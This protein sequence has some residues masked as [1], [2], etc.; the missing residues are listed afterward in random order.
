MPPR[1]YVANQRKTVTRRLMVCCGCAGFL[2]LA[3][4]GVGFLPRIDAS[5]K[6]LPHHQDSAAP[7]KIPPRLAAN[8]GKLPLSATPMGALIPGAQVS[9]PSPSAKAARETLKPRQGLSNLPVAAQPV[10]SATLGQEDARYQVAAVGGALRAQ[11]PA[12]GLRAAFTRQGM[13]VRTGGGT[14]WRLALGG[15][16]YGDRLE[17]VREAVPQSRANRVEYRRGPLV[18]WYVNGPAGLEQGFT[19][20]APPGSAASGTRD[21][22][23]GTPNSSPLTIALEIGGDLTV[24]ADSTAEGQGD[25]RAEGLTLRDGH[26]Q[27]VL[28]YTGLTAHD[29]SGRALVAW[30][31]LGREEVRLRVEDAG[32]RYP[33]VLDPFVQQAKLTASDGMRN[34]EF[35]YSLGVSSD[36]STIVAGARGFNSFR[37]AAYVFVKPGGGWATTSSFTAKLTASDGLRYGQFGFSVGVSGYAVVAGAPF[38]TIGSNSGQGAGYVF[39]SPILWP[40][41]LS[42]GTHLVG[43]SSLETVMLTNLGSTPLSI[44][45]L[46]VVEF[47][48]LAPIG[49]KGGD[50]AIL[51][52]STCVAGGSVAGPGACAINVAFKPTSAGVKSATLVV[53]DSDPSSPQ[54]VNLQGSGTAV[55]LSETSI[56]LR[57]QPVGTTGAPEAVTLTN[58]GKTPLRIESLSLWGTNARDFAIQPSSTCV[59]ESSVAG[60]GTCTINLTFKPTAAGARSATLVINDSDPSSPQTVSLIGTGTGLGLSG[61]PQGSG[62]EPEVTSSHRSPLR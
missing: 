35:G 51:P 16:G 8:Y 39:P 47:L 55:R 34:D 11:N 50:F 15:Y 36:G 2:F 37:G 61:A 46:N 27:A 54:T 33:V 30:L 12:Q 19:L 23:H 49:T 4:I 60:A 57:P 6:T 41:S 32:A 24:S 44:S 43:S 42:F 7:T 53:A 29:A 62:A 38:V 22:G 25:A 40:A 45:G 3:I 31:E 56:D 5:K 1:L 59:A 18:E 17:K 52:S 20:A 58:L 14:H 10:I 9:L 21:T 13:E 48:P 28:R 26:G